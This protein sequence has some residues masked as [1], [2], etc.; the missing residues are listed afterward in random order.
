M[1][2]YTSVYHWILCQ[3]S[4]PCLIKVVR[5][6][7]SDGW[8]VRQ[9]LIQPYCTCPLLT[10]KVRRQRA[11]KSSQPRKK[12]TAEARTYGQRQRAYVRI[13]LIQQQIIDPNSLQNVRKTS[14]DERIIFVSSKRD[15]DTRQLCFI[16]SSSRARYGA[17]MSFFSHLEANRMGNHSDTAC[18][19]WTAL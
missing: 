8:L 12:R 7:A 1:V 4:G 17:A 3:V 2:G 9:S 10:C 16:D 19:T 15:A 6:Q 13:P 5:P 11:T 18:A 14:N